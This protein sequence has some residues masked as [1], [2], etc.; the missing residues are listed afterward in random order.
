MA[1]GLYTVLPAG[2]RWNEAYQALLA[3]ALPAV[4]LVLGGLW[5]GFTSL[6]SRW[7]P[8]PLAAAVMA[9]TLPCLTGFLHLDGFMDVADAMLCARPREEKLRI[10]KD[11]HAGSFAVVSLACLLLLQAGACYSILE[12]GKA[13]TALW[14][15]PVIARA[16]AALAVMTIRPMAQSGYGKMNY[17]GAS[18]A[19][20]WFCALCLVAA[21]AVMFALDW[22]GGAACLAA[23]AG[24]AASCAWAVNGLGGMNGDIAGWSV[25][26]AEVLGLAALACL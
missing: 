8:S 7:M 21:M 11:P 6:F 26:C 19:K 5:F 22:R 14:G 2:R 23:M 16:G 24:F 10:L 1:L 9:M 25:C 20:R 15:L 3:P 12:Q 4:G 17:S 18:P 13:L